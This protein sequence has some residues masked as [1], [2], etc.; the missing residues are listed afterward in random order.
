[1]KMFTDITT[2]PDGETADPARVLWIL[3][4]LVYFGG[5]VAV[6][7]QGKFDMQ[8][9]GIGLAAVLAGGAGGVKMKESTEPKAKQP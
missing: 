2:G 1:M 4:T 8:T 3:G 6:M 5:S 7:I 9:Y